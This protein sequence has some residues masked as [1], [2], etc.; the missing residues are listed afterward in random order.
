[1]LDRIRISRWRYGISA[2]VAAVGLFVAAPSV[3]AAHNSQPVTLPQDQTVNHDYFAAGSSVEID[4]TVNGDVYVAGGQIII[5]GIVNGDV[6]A[7]GGSI[8]V[9]GTVN[10]NVRAAGG[11]V[12]VDGHVTKNVSVAGGNVQLAHHAVIDG[13]VA[14]ASGNLQDSSTTAGDVNAAVG[15]LTVGSDAHIGGTV[16]YWSNRTAT[17]ANGSVAGSVTHHTPQMKHAASWS[18]AGALFMALYW[19]VAAYI[20]A[21]LLYV[22]LPRHSQ[23]VTKTVR[24]RPW[25]S[26][27]WGVAAVIAIPIVG[28]VLM[29]TVIGIPLALSLWALYAIAALLAPV[30]IIMT[31]RELLSARMADVNTFL[32]LLLAAVIYTLITLIP[33]VG[34]LFIVITG[35]MGLGA[36]LSSGRGAYLHLRRKNEI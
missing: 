29:I 36:S 22:W 5:N 17:I 10:G 32:M 28:I 6:L 21:T 33:I 12:V 31:L 23:A 4:G 16:V 34:G 7:A 3:L 26:L 1:M 2:L 35:L 27:G 15:Q 14:A 19:L 25:Q 11:S 9:D 24:E 13:S 30:W 18:F 8:T 20:L